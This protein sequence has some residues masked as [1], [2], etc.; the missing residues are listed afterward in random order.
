MISASWEFK[1]ICR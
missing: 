1:Q